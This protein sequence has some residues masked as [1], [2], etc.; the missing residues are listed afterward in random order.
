[1]A[2][3]LTGNGDVVTVGAVPVRQGGTA[4]PV[5]G[6]SAINFSGRV[7]FTANFKNVYHPFNPPAGTG[8]YVTSLMS[9]NVSLPDNSFAKSGN[10]FR[11][12][13]SIE[14]SGG[15]V[16]KNFNFNVFSDLA[17]L[18]NLNIPK[19]A[20]QNPDDG[21]GLLYLIRPD[22]GGET[23]NFKNITV[24][25][26]VFEQTPYGELFVGA[27]GSENSSVYLS[28][29]ANWSI[30]WGGATMSPLIHFQSLNESAN[31]LLLLTRPS[32]STAGWNVANV[33]P[34][35]IN[36]QNAAGWFAYDWSGMARGNYEYRYLALDAAGNVKNS[37]QGQMALNDGAPT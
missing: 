10:T 21:F 13:V 35:Q 2:K 37:G 15:A 16:G 14:C 32:G 12:G 28:A 19:P 30:K 8:L 33:P 36:G 1:M 34:M 22:N 9:L 24:K 17:G 23:F 31:R 26:S 25:V 5:G 4:N 29:Y 7:G 20:G 3:P 18:R 6:V 11:V 27:G